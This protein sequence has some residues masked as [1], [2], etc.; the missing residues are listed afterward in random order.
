MGEL[1]NIYPKIAREV[2]LIRAVFIFFYGCDVKI[3]S[4][5]TGLPV[6]I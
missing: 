5:H 3:W 6:G 1:Y 2:M 4:S